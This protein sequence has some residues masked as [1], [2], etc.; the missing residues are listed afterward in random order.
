MVATKKRRLTKRG[1][2]NFL[3]GQFWGEDEKIVIGERK[4]G[5]EGFPNVRIMDPKVAKRY[6]EYAGGKMTVIFE[7]STMY[8][9]LN[10]GSVDKWKFDTA[11]HEFLAQF[12]CYFELGYA[13]SL[14]IYEK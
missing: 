1:L 4:P 3:K 6:C 7:G 14:S 12:G 10:Y 9:L 13:W 2:R 8:E 11:L 5:E